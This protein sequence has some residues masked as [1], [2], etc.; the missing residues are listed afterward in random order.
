MQ[1][2]G[3][4]TS[5][6]DPGHATTSDP[7][8]LPPARPTTEQLVAEHA[9]VLYRLA[10]RLCRSPATAEDL[11]QEAFVIAHRQLPKLREP[12]TARKWLYRIL[13][14]CWCREIAKE[15]K[16]TTV[17]WSEVDEPAVEPPVAFDSQALQ[18][19]LE[20]LPDEFRAPVVLFYFEE[21]K[22]REIAEALDCPI[23][24]VMSR[25]ARGK[26][27]LRQLLANDDGSV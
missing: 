24:T 22:Y 23:G 11:V 26:A 1:S 21:M 2:T 9:D 6:D 15:K 19:A 13:H 7:V 12:Q 27:L 20:S 14:S 3:L 5:G 8:D 4:S 16:R 18:V 25:L 17:S 10:F